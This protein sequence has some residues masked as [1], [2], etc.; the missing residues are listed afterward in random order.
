MD[1]GAGEGEFEGSSSKRR[2]DSKRDSSWDVG[3]GGMGGGG[4]GGEV[5]CEAIAVREK[6]TRDRDFG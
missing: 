4:E 3:A 2:V 1:G 5:S 6:M